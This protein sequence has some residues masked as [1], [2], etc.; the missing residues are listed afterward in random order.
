MNQIAKLKTVHV[1]LTNLID[2]VDNEV[3]KNTKFNTLE[4]KLNNFENKIPVATTL[5]QIDQYNTDKKKLEKQKIGDVN[6]KFQVHV[7]Y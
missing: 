6:E 2:V 1:D 7:E 4:T 5:I 3:V